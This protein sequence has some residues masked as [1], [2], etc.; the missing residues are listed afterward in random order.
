[1]EFLKRKMES[2]KWKIF[3]T[4]STFHFPLSIKE[5]SFRELE[6]LARAF[7]TVFFTF[8]LARVARNESG[9]FQ[10]RAQIDVVF[11]QRARDAVPHRAGLSG[12]SA[13]RDVDENVELVR[14]VSQLQRLMNNHPQGFVRKIIFKLAAINFYLPAARTQIN[15]RRRSLSASRS[16]IL[17]ICHNLVD[18]RCQMS[19]A[20]L[21]FD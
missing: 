20:S 7:L 18:V 8:L 19:D 13:A 5:L 16:V 2:G 4:F 10:S 3:L 9:F 6:T 14:R 1:M 17:Y 11:H 12:S 21:V 15:A